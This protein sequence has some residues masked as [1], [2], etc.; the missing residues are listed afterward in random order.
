MQ[1]FV[2]PLVGVRIARLGSPYLGG[3]WDDETIN[4]QLKLICMR[5]HRSVWHARV[6]TEFRVAFGGPRRTR[7]RTG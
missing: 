2:A 1:T 4:G 5:A 3:T 7:Q 6:L